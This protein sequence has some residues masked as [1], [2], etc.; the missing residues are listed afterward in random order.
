MSSPDLANEV[1]LA[2]KHP[3]TYHSW[4]NG[5][6]ISSSSLSPSPVKRLA[7]LKSV[8]PQAYAKQTGDLKPSS[9]FPLNQL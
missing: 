7:Y 5:I 6:W 3:R 2:I 9:Q 8:T 4:S 1:G